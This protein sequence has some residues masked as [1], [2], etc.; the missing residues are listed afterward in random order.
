[1]TALERDYREIDRH[2]AT[3]ICR[4]AGTAAEELHRAAL[5]VGQGHVC[6]DLTTVGP[7]GWWHGLAEF[8]VVGTPGAFTPL[9]L[10]G[11]GRLYLHRYWRYEHDLA[12]AVLHK[13]GQ[14]VT[15]DE[16]LLR[17]G[18]DRLFPDTIPGEVDWQR[19]AATAAVRTGFA[20]ISGGPGTGKTST[21]VK[22]LALLL[23]QAAGRPLAVALAA[24]TGKAAVR[25]QESIRI[26]RER[27]DVAAEVR[28][29]IP[30]EVV[31]LHRLLGAGGSGRFR[32]DRENPLPHDLVVVD[33]ASMVA[34]PLMA[35][36]VTALK[37]RCRLILLGDRDQ[38]ASVEAG[39]VLGDICD[40][41]RGH[42]FSPA[43]VSLSPGSPPWSSRQPA[44]NRWPTPWSS[45]GRATASPRTAGLPLPAG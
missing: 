30:A 2:F 3:F 42:S 23:E 39:A 28:E 33:E 27:L 45:S 14:L 15:L 34:L 41:G 7:D 38:L 1:M 36:L 4:L 19:V 22:I 31:T 10:D 9:V 25:L 37:P 18:L 43:F 35:R 16:A 24:P 12:A 8:P 20:V 17:A 21:V 44:R 13:G 26:A 40:T 6:V 5:L 11:A 29:R 32:H